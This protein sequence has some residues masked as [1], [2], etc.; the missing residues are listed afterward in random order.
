MALQI[1]HKI[2]PIITQFKNLEAESYLVDGSKMEEF[3]AWW[4]RPHFHC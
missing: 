1:S 2:P 4:L 3:S